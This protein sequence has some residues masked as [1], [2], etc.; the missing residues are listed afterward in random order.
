MLGGQVSGRAGYVGQPL[1]A[2]RALVAGGH[3]RGRHLLG[4]LGCC[5]GLG[6]GRLLFRVKQRTRQ[7]VCR[8]QESK[9]GHVSVV[10]YVYEWL[11]W[12]DKSLYTTL[13]DII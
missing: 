1:R 4:P 6:G 10:G 2:S 13:Y 11:L 12:G 3:V 7:G 5:G 9:V 8:V